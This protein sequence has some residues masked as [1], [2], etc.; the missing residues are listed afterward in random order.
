MYQ[1]GKYFLAPCFMYIRRNQEM[2]CKISARSSVLNYSMNRSQRSIS[3]SFYDKSLVFKGSKYEKYAFFE[4][5]H[6]SIG[7][8]KCYF[9][10]S[11]KRKK[12]DVSDGRAYFSH[13]LRRKYFEFFVDNNDVSSH[14]VESVMFQQS[15]GW[16]FS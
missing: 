9:F 14:G 12:I 4:L 3:C 7:W 15:N 16:E 10:L 11:E 5:K 8:K 13:D 2:K 1:K 6:T